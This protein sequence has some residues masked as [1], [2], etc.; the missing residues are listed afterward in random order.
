MIHYHLTHHARLTIAD[1]GIDLAWI[2]RVLENPLRTERDRAD[3][4]L[5]HALGRIPEYGSRV[6][7]VMYNDGAMP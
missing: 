6:L 7:R 3:S 2:E 5:G 1:R 4:D